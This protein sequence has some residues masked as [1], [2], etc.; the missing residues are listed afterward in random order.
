MKYVG[1]LNCP[2]RRIGCHSKCKK[3]AEYKEKL[4]II[5]KNRQMYR[6]NSINFND[7]KGVRYGG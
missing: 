3:Y 1:C 7:Y 4:E 6:I 2:V 5:R